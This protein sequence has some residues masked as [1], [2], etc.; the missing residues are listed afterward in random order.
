MG[1][2]HAMQT[3]SRSEEAPLGDSS[4]LAAFP[5]GQPRQDVPCHSCKLPGPAPGA[6]HN[7]N[8]QSYKQLNLRGLPC[9]P[10]VYI[11]DTGLR[12]THYD[13][14]GRVGAGA[15]AVGTS[16]ADDQGHGTHVSGTAAGSVH[17]VAPSAIIHPVKVSPSGQS[18]SVSRVSH[19]YPV[20]LCCHNAADNFEATCVEVH[21]MA[22]YAAIAPGCQMLHSMHDMRSILTMHDSVRYDLHHILLQVMDAQGNGAYSNIIAGI[23]W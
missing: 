20:Q 9:N 22:P 12:T 11:L 13:F 17:G 1:D 15:S 2:A 10:A 8:M 7:T 18:N 6:L 19:S 23:Q 5:G 21:F 3:A 4:W 14:T 16:V